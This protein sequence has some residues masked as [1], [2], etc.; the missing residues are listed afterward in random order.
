MG[1]K[2]PDIGEEF[3]NSTIEKINSKTKPKKKNKVIKKKN[4]CKKNTKI[5]E[6]IKN[7]L[8]LSGGEVKGIAHIGALKALEELKYLEKIDTY[9][10]TS[11]GALIS[12]LIVVGYTPDDL[13][14]FIMMFDINKMKSFNLSNII[15]KFMQIIEQHGLDDGDRIEMIVKKMFEKKN[16]SSTVT[17]KELYEKTKKNLIVTA[18]CMNDANIYYL[19]YENYPDMEVIK[20]IRMSISIPFY[21]VPV[22]YGTKKYIDGGCID[23]YPISLFDD[24]LDNVIGIY[25]NEQREYIPDIDNLEESFKLAVRCLMSG[26]K[27]NS[28]RGYEDYTIIL[29]LPSI[30]IILSQITSEIKKQLFDVGYNITKNKLTD[31]KFTKKIAL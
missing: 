16:I 23:N 6:K 18:S 4:N 1:D 24:K 21:F 5:I 17:F 3:L 29:D 22:K 13:Y 15:G 9:A 19:S 8:V 11:I 2:N 27:K 10:G 28:I 14:D 7:I 20:A 30:S 26:V 25:L 12:A 31:N